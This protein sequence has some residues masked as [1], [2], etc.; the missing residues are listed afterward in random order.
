MPEIRLEERNR[1]NNILP[2]NNP[3]CLL[4]EQFS[5]VQSYIFCVQRVQAISDCGLVTTSPPLLSESS[6]GK[7]RRHK[8]ARSL[9][10]ITRLSK[11]FSHKL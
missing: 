3:S 6:L 11:P 1:Q 5:S 2:S 7:S 4:T 10:I 8:I 9:I